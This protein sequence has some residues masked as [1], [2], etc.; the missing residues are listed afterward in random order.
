VK[1]FRKEVNLRFDT[2][3]DRIGSMMKWTVG[4]LGLF[5][6]LITIL[7]AVSQFGK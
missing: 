6:T 5:G 7:L 3:Y 2:M 1:D 4:T